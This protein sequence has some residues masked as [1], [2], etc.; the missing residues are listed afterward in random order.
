MTN[1]LLVG[2]LTDNAPKPVRLGADLNAYT[3]SN[4]DLA[5]LSA[6]G[7]GYWSVTYGLDEGSK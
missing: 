2:N 7:A 5:K 1:M 3:S 4:D 6:I